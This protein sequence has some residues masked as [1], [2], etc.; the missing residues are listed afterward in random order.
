MSVPVADDDSLFIA[1]ALLGQLQAL[2]TEIAG[3]RAAK[4]PECLHR[5]RVASRRLRTMLDLFDAWLPPKA[6]AGW[7]KGVRRITRAL[8]AARDLDVQMQL[9][10]DFTAAQTDPRLRTGLLRL[11]LR[12]Q[13]ARQ[14][15]QQRVCR[16]LDELEGGRLV[17]ALEDALRQLPRRGGA[18]AAADDGSGLPARANAVIAARLDDLLDYEIFL[19][20]PP[21]AANQYASL[22]AMRIAAK[23]LRY[24]LNIFAPLFHGALDEP[25][26]AAR[27]IQD[28]LGNL[29]DCDVW[30]AFLPAFLAGERRRML[31]YAGSLRGF[32]RLAAGVEAL[33]EDRTRA[34]ECI[35]GEFQ[36]FWRRL[37]ERQSWPRLRALLE[38]AAESSRE[39][40]CEPEIDGDD[41]GGQRCP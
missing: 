7:T 4:D 36:A 29:H 37:Q 31:D 3:V 28:Q 32:S 13:Q 19:D 14:R 40:E 23:H 41:A 18:R 34:R 24:T 35:H 10:R 30:M 16:I 22:H 38:S 5:M 33:L 21:D 8:G 25:I 12:L 1:R 2:T 39:D 15:R 20:A 11:L 9:V 27:T 6:L 26:K 17:G